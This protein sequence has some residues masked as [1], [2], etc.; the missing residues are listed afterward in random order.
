MTIISV[1]LSSDARGLKHWPIVDPA[2]FLPAARLLGHDHETLHFAGSDFPRGWNSAASNS[3]AALVSQVSLFIVEAPV[4]C[5]GDKWVGFGVLLRV[6][7]KRQH[8][9]AVGISNI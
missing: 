5:A 7:K 9:C 6:T 3:V 1:V 2:L 4:D 8:K